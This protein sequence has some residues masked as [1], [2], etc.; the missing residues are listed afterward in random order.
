[1]LSAIQSCVL[2]YNVM[3]F[4]PPG[5]LYSIDKAGSKLHLHCEGSGSPV[6]LLHHGLTGHSLDWSWVQPELAKVTK[7]C[8]F[9]RTGYGWSDAIGRERTSDS[10]ADE[11]H[12][13]LVEAGLEKEQFIFAGHSIASLHMST[14]IHKYLD[15]HDVC[16]LV[17]AD[18]MDPRSYVFVSDWEKRVTAPFPWRFAR[19]ALPSGIM[20]LYVATS[21]F[22]NITSV[23]KLPEAVHTTY[24]QNMFRP[25][26]SDSVILEYEYMP[27]SV[28]QA[29]GFGS[30]G[31]LSLIV[32][33]A[34]KGMNN[35]QLTELSSNSTL[36]YLPDAPHDLIMMQAYKDILVRHIVQLVDMVRISKFCN[37]MVPN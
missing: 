24:V 35:S 32:L 29:I 22:P 10:H 19:A 37:T 7:T 2:A 4:Q 27:M 12:A 23:R 21:T 30:L 16:G 18:C 5:N 1:V 28:H 11:L 15:Q 20:W 14:F 8:S 3:H 6:V 17:C 9:D 36:L 33:A 31:D 25:I 26:Y 13:L 34:G